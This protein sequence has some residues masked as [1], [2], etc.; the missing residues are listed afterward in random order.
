MTI[1]ISARDCEVHA[2]AIAVCEVLLF[3]NHT[4]DARPAAKFRAVP[5]GRLRSDHSRLLDVLNCC[6]ELI[7]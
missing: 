6:K 2:A 3:G 1:S 4:R 5:I 7:L